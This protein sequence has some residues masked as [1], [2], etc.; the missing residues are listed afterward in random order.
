MT[1]EHPLGFVGLGAIGT[2]LARALLEA[3]HH[4]VVHDIEA[5]KAESLGPGA[6]VARSCS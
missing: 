5:S 1:G 6:Q 2:P 4:L 3:R